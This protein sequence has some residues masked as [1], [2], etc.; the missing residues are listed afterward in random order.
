MA[1][2]G[3]A[4]AAAAGANSHR[5]ERYDPYGSGRGWP[6]RPRISRDMKQNSDFAC[7]YYGSYYIETH[8]MGITKYWDYGLMALVEENGKVWHYY[9]KCDKDK[10][11]WENACD[12]IVEIR[13]MI[14]HHEL[15]TWMGEGVPGMKDITQYACPTQPWPS[16]YMT[17]RIRRHRDDK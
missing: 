3:F 17:E 6:L 1:F 12:L 16:H 2:G 15:E 13:D 5:P 8:F 9:W 11:K 14:E 7:T 10:T 4:V